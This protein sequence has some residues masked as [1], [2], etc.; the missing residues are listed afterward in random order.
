M[1]QIFLILE[2]NVCY[3]LTRC[4]TLIILKRGGHSMTTV[5][6]VK[7]HPLDAE[8]S[9]SLRAFEKFI[10]AY[11]D[12]HPD[13]ELIEVDVYDK[14]IPSLDKDLLEAMDLA[15]KGKALTSTQADKLDHYYRRTEEFLQAD[16]VVIVNPLW[17]MQIP[18][19]LLSWINTINVSGKTFRY[20]KEGVEGLAAGKKILHIQASGG[21]YEEQDHASQYLRAI[22]KFLG[23]EDFQG[24]YIEG[25]AY[26]PD[27]ADDI[28]EQAVSRL[29]HLA[30]TF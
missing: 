13:D 20:T 5:L 10:S 24:V 30:Q 2:Q 23:V 27:K 16:K 28:F 12:H 19:H 9:Y 8:Q 29:E 14:T 25:H 7:G 6:I 4:Y 26:A 21:V 18:S 15:K 11:K 17:N 22:F 3:L 1:L